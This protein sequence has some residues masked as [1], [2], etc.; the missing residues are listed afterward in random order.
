MLTQT[1]REL[2]ID[3][4]INRKVY[5]EVPPKVEYTLTQTATE[6]IPFI[7]HLR[8]WG[9]KQMKKE[10]F[11]FETTLA[12][13]TY[14]EKI[15]DAKENGYFTTLLFF[16][17]KNTELAKERVKIRVSEGGHNTPKDV[18]ERRYFNGIKNLF[19]IYLPI[20]DQVFIFDNSEGK[21]KL[22]AEKNFGEDI[23]IVQENEFNELKNNYD[24]R[25]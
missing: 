3:G 10:N 18:I 21:H 19:E 16:W 20:V 17:L 4:M 22:I 8:E 14:K 25:K 5:P 7:N 2:E 9:E 12:T 6:I 15:L 13:R 11:A 1:L 23:I 24:N